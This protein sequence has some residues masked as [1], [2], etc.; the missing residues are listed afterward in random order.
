VI[1]SLFLPHL[2][3]PLGVPSPKTDYTHENY[4]VAPRGITQ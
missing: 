3:I 1:C 4:C 2:G